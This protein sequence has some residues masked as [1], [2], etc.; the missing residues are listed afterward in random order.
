MTEYNGI[1]VGDLITAY[2]KGIWRVESF[3]QRFY[4]KSFLDMYYGRHYDAI[5]D[6][7]NVN[8][9]TVKVGDE[10]SPLI[11]HSFVCD[12][13]GKLYTGKKPKTSQCDASYCAP[14][15]EYL[16]SIEDHYNALKTIINGK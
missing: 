11:N 5:T 7:Y 4:D 10:Y 9:Q 2:N 12:S 1:K 16:K 14:A 13:N 6:T 8:G 15:S 3:V